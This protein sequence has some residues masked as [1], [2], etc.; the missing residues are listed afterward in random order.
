MSISDVITSIG[1]LVTI[2]A[3]IVGTL[4]YI[5]T[6]Q[7]GKP[8]AKVLIIIST[9][10]T[11]IIIGIVGTAVFISASTTITI[12]GHKTVSIPGFSAATEPP[13][14]TPSP[15]PTPQVIHINQIMTCTDCSP[16]GYNF[17]L[18]V[19]DAT[20]DPAKQQVTLLVGVQNN[21]SDT[22]SPYIRF[23]KLQDT[24]TG[25]TTSGEGDGFSN[26]Q[27]TAKQ[28]ILFRPTFQFVPVAGHLY[29]L[30]GNISSEFDLSPITIK[31]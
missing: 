23:L 8:N 27:I 21:T 24:Q 22:F 15:T 5:I 11:V 17:S 4:L 26:F 7:A 16:S 18:I 9:I 28:L 29:S 1:T 10:T 6:K 19:R 14:A 13:T 20:I 31:F 2:A 12:N 30:S 25:I 3:V